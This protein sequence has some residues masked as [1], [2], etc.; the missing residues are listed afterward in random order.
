[1]SRI[2][3]DRWKTDSKIGT[4]LIENFAFTRFIVTGTI[5][6]LPHCDIGNISKYAIIPPFRNV[7]F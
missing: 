6:R 2:F 5:W 1:M 3:G 4:T 7:S